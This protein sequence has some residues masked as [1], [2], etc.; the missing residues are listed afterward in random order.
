MTAAAH[1]STRQRIVSAAVDLTSEG[2]WSAVTMARLAQRVGVSR[3]TVYNEVGSKPQLAEAVIAD[4]LGRFM[5]AVNE[6]FDEH[7]DDPVASMR[8][9]TQA[10]LL[11]ADKSDFLRSIVSAT[12]G[13]DTE[14]LPALTTRSSMV[15][16]GASTVVRT[17]LAPLVP[18]LTVLQIDA[19]VDVVVR[20]VIS[21]VMQPGGTADSTA[22]A[23]A[24]LTER[25]LSK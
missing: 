8:A 22:D 19:L 18:D 2:G 25:V 16:E 20:T 24:W 6:A 15:V 13:V 3:Q 9:A 1:I 5:E 23:I 14:L 7:Q 10:V 17:R 21:H 12:Q 4:E 11:R